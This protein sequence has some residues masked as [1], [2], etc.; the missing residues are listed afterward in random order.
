MKSPPD[1][2]GRIRKPATPLHTHGWRE[3][4]QPV[5]T[6]KKKGGKKFKILA[7]R[8]SS[9]SLLFPLDLSLSV[10]REQGENEVE[11]RN[12]GRERGDESGWR[13]RFETDIAKREK[14]ERGFCEKVMQSGRRRE[15]RRKENYA[16][17]GWR[18]SSANG[19]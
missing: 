15:R 9:V 6:V 13:E 1:E 7:P 18:E 17:G 5:W 10:F 16:R 12:E 19:K 4:G 3:G 14:N 8:Q 11:G 2:K